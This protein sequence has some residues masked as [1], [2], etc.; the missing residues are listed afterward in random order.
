M[1]RF[2]PHRIRS[3]DEPMHARS[4]LRMRL[5]M[6]LIGLASALGGVVFFLTQHATGWVIACAAIGVLAFADVLVVV[7]H[8]RQGPHYQPGRDIPPYRP[9]ETPED[10]P[11]PRKP[12]SQRTREQV[13]LA[14]MGTCLTLVVLAWTLVRLFSPGLA[15]AMSVV[16]AFIP[17]FAVMV[18]NAR[19]RNW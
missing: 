16:A 8:I 17:P 2:D 13:Y 5:T 14:M 7:H 18:A 11:P 19:G 6:A 3:G 10:Y 15:V 12:L 4:P 1:T 9:V